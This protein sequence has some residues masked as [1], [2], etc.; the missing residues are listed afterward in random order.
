MDKYVQDATRWIPEAKMEAWGG[1]SST[2]AG[3]GYFRLGLATWTSGWGAPRW[4]S[5]TEATQELSGDSHANTGGSQQAIGV[6]APQTQRAT[7]TGGERH[8]WED[9]NLLTDFSILKCKKTIKNTIQNSDSLTNV[10][11]MGRKR[12]K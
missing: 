6:T 1:C 12:G 3:R 11:Y 2:A 10:K 7:A 5:S 4:G 9:E 8:V